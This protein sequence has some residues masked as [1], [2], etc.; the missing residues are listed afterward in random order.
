MQNSVNA[1]FPQSQYS[2]YVEPG[3]PLRL[4][5]IK[6]HSAVPTYL[7]LAQNMKNCLEDLMI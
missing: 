4:K 3:V 1:T 7:Q 5:K 6:T 2:H